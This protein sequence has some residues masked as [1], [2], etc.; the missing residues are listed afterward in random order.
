VA[1]PSGHSLRH[2][3]RGAALQIDSLADAR[4]YQAL[5]IDPPSRD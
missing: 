4:L 2:D 3:F 1:V 5:G